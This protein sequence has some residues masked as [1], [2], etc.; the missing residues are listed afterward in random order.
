M[1]SDDDDEEG[2]KR[3][4][5]DGVDEDGD[6]AG[7]QVAEL[8]EM[9]AA[10]ELDKQPRREEHEQHQ[11]D[12]HRAPVRHPPPPDLS[13]LHLSIDRSIDDGW[14]IDR[15]LPIYMILLPAS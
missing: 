14:M 5:D 4:V 11:P 2:D 12:H 10:G 1:H 6:G 3:E 9:V 13:S 15:L 7:L 8:H